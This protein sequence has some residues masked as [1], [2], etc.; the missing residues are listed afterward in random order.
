MRALVLCLLATAAFAEP[1]TLSAAD[2][3][4]VY[5]EWTPAQGAPKGV[6]V[7]F[8]QAHA[9][10]SEYAPIAPKLAQAGWASLA[11]DQRSGDELFGAKNRTAAQFKETPGY[12]EAMPDL[13]A[14]LAEGVKRNGGKP[15]IVVGS[16]YSAT[17]VFALAAKHPS[18]VRAVIAFSPGEYFQDKHY[19]RSA[20]AQL[21]VPL[22][23]TSASDPDEVRRAKEVLDASPSTQKVQHTPKHG[24]HGA[25]TLRTDR[26]AA[27]AQEN[28]DALM[29][30]LSS[31]R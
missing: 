29:K 9:N 21:K 19:A 7:L 15:V 24:V 10:H 2:G 5:G 1:V 28:W 25:S 31:L 12:L 8:H 30:F 4:K 26:N 17:L 22:Y 13:E 6:M 18:D 14:A 16:S 27:G 3:T 23:V 11:V 20:A